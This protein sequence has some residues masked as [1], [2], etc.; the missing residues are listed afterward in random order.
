MRQI[1]LTAEAFGQNIDLNYRMTEVEDPAIDPRELA[2][3]YINPVRTPEG[4]IHAAVNIRIL[5]EEMLSTF[6]ACSE[7]PADLGGLYPVLRPALRLF[8][9]P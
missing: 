2:A 5:Q 6:H 1:Y 3:Q 7:L 8:A 4:H 9:E